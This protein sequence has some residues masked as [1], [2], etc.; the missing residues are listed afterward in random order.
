MNAK[1]Y[2]IRL[3]Q[4]DEC[5]KPGNRCN[6]KQSFIPITCAVKL[7]GR[8]KPAPRTCK[9]SAARS[10]PRQ[11]S[12]EHSCYIRHDLFRWFIFPFERLLKIPNRKAYKIFET[13]LQPCLFSRQAAQASL[14][15][16][17]DFPPH[18]SLRFKSRSTRWAVILLLKVLVFPKVK[19]KI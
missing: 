1:A 2:C 13:C 19:T 11:R 9:T 7:P 15:R 6:V 10:Q 12:K 18:H 16:L 17:F 3:A 5:Q 8:Y 4:I 14:C